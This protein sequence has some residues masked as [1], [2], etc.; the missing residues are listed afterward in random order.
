M[1]LLSFDIEEFNLPEEYGE[2]VEFAQQI[3]VSQ[4]GLVRVLDLLKLHNIKATFYSTVIFAENSLPLIKQI[5]KQGHE[6]A[7]HGYAHG[8]EQQEGDFAR[9]KRLLEEISGKPVVGFRSPRLAEFNREIL[10]NAGYKYDSSINPT[11]LPGRYNN[12]TSPRGLHR[13]GGVIEVPASVSYPFRVPLFWLSMHNLPL[14]MY[15]NMCYRALQEDGFLNIYFHPWEFSDQLCDYKVV[16]G[17]IKRNSG[18]KC[19]KRLERLILHLK[20]KG[21]KFSTTK[22]YIKLCEKR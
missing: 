4:K 17:F 18:E 7:S 12:Y 3:E 9:S 2:E 8:G 14:G 11:F 5:V 1:V 16:P 19:L 6:I 20:S 10:A 13:L 15:F 22:E 21:C